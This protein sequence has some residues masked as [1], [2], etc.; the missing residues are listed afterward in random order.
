M[1]GMINRAIKDLVTEVAGERAWTRVVD[2]AGLGTYEF[3]DARSYDDEITTRLVGAAADELGVT[4]DEVLVDFGRHWVLFTG[5]EGWGPV[6]DMAGHDVRSFVEGLDSLHARV[7]VA[8]P[9][10]RMPSFRVLVSERDHIEV[11]YESSRTG[12]VSMVLGLFG[13][14][15]E[16]FGESWQ[17]EHAGRI[18]D[19]SG[20]LFVLDRVVAVVG[21]DDGLDASRGTR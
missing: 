15:A 2:G 11:V 16:R 21:A 12:L 9:N 4:A 8:M 14:L 3:A 17:V 18:D 6:L 19:D 5:S 10:S 13:G 20:E 7:Q 1:Y